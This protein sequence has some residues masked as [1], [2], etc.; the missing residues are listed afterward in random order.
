MNESTRSTGQNG[1]HGPNRRRRK[2]VSEKKIAAAR[3]QR[4]VLSGVE[5]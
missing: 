4:G 2:A 1:Y 3:L 5:Y